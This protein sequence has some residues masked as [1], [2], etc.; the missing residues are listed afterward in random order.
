MRNRRTCGRRHRC[1]DK[2]RG[3]GMA[4]RDYETGE[5]QIKKTSAQSLQ[6]E[7]ANKDPK[8]DLRLDRKRGTAKAETKADHRR[9]GDCSGSCVRFGVRQHDCRS[10]I[11]LLPDGG[12]ILEGG[13]GDG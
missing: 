6:A 9:E 12:A 11:D 7:T 8:K 13:E 10:N 2:D 5:N 4:C 1:N 3:R